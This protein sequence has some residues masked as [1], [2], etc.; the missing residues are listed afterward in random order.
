MTK[1]VVSVRVGTPYLYTHGHKHI[2]FRDTESIDV[3][4]AT[5]KDA[6]SRLT[7]LQRKYEGK[8]NNLRFEEVHDCGCYRQCDCSPTL[9]LQGD[10]LESDVEYNFR[11][12]RETEQKK[13]QRERD[14]RELA[15]IAARL[16]K[17][18]T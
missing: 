1:Q 15:A 6:I 5:L 3:K 7:A 16:G 11:V 4:Y 18:V 10:R 2:A 12:A 17:T 9:Y 14:E 13:Q 8:Y